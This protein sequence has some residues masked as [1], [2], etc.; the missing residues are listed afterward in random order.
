MIENDDLQKI[1]S[2]V[3]TKED[4]QDMKDDI[5]GLKD[6]VRSLVLEIDKMVVFSSQ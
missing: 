6:V 3:A 1:V 4:I 5:N 2:V